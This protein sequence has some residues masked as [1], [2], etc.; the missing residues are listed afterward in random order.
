MDWAKVTAW[1]DETHLCFGF[2]ALYTTCFTVHGIAY[3]EGSTENTDTGGAVKQYTAI[4]KLPFK[5]LCE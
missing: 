2:G 5:K 1:R 4:P 3:D